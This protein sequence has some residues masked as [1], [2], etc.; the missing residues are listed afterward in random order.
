MIEVENRWEGANRSGG[1]IPVPST[2][3]RSFR[4]GPQP[5]RPAGSDPTEAR[6]RLWHGQPFE[7]EPDVV[8]PACSRF[9]AACTKAYFRAPKREAFSA[10]LM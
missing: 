4:R 7:L 9:N 5:H 10:K 1:R 3:P 6:A 2:S 8:V